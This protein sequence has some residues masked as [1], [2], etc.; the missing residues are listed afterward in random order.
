[1]PVELRKRKAP[2]APAPAP[3]P[4]KTSKVAKV[5]AKTKADVAGK[6]AQLSTEEEKEDKAEKEEEKPAVAKKVAVGDIVALDA[7]GGEIETNE[8]EKTSLK[9]LVEKSAAGVVLFTYPKASTPGC[10]S[11]TFPTLPRPA[12]TCTNPSQAQPRSASSAT[13]TRR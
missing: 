6:K 9:E 12:H 1:M 8:G 4:K 7:F 13:P 11:T 3:A 2:A 5:V 10:Q